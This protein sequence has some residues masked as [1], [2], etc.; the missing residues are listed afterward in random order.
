MK[1]H[2]VIMF[3]FQLKYVRLHAHKVMKHNIKLMV[4]Y[5]KRLYV[6]KTLSKNAAIAQKQCF[7]MATEPKIHR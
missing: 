4:R 3:R 2:S 6:L 1:F 7:C 5:D